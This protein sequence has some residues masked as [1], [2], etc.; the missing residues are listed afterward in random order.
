M[1]LRYSILI[2]G[3]LILAS[4]NFSLAEDITPPPGYAPPTPAPT[5]GPLYPL[6]APSLENGAAIYA[7]KCA[8]CHGATGMGDGAQ[9]AQLPSAPAPLGLAV[10][11]NSRVPSAWFEAVTKGNLEKFMPPFISLSETERWDVVAYALSLS[12]SQDAIAQGQTIFA[13]NCAE[14]HS[15]LAAFAD[16]QKLAK[17][18]MDDLIGFSAKGVGDKMPGYEGK[19]SADDLY[20]VNAYVRSL[21]FAQPQATATPLP[22]TATLEP[23]A[24]TDPNFTPEPTATTDPNITPTTTVE[25]SPTP[26]ASPTPNMALGRFSGTISNGSGGKVPADLEINLIGFDH[27]TSTGQFDQT[28]D[29]KSP[30]DADGSFVFENIDLP[31]GRVFYAAVTYDGADYASE[32]VSIDG[33]INAFDLPIMIYDATTDVSALGVDQ[34]HILVDVGV[35]DQIQFVEFFVVSNN[36][37]KTVIAA[38]EGEPLVIVPLP[39]GYSSLQFEQGGIGAPYVQ[40]ADGFGDPTAIKAQGGSQLVFGFTLPYSKETV[41]FSQPITL[42]INTLNVLLPVGVKIDGEGFADAGEQTLGNGQVFHMY[43]LQS[44]KPGDVVTFTVS[45]KPTTGGAQQPA[46]SGLD[47]AQMVLIGAGILGLLLIG[48][49]AYM[50]WRD[51]GRDDEDDE[52][53]EDESAADSADDVIDAILALDDQFRSG[54][55]SEEAYKQRRAELKSRLKGKV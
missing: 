47:P 51:R 24:T 12:M 10:F 13:A 33:T 19:L 9:A 35:E 17:L 26:E 31:S 49:G 41:A 27:D 21:T 11:A 55:I 54:N 3:A 16:Q 1:K 45:G 43:T 23:T 2:L 15:D 48:G 28:V 30:V 7:E 52:D 36:S 42:P 22:P 6:Q 37:D 32:F 8:P 29:L 5:M 18:S 46:V 25:S 38:T 20:A 34:A 14:C 4:C 53:G 39:A 40:T 44:V 50:L